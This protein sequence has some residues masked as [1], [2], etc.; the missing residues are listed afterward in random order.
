MHLLTQSALLKA[1]GWSLF[2]SC[3][4]M[5]LLWLLYR[6]LLAIFHKASAHA[7]HGLACLVLG[8]GLVWAALSG[9]SPWPDGIFWTGEHTGASF[10]Q[11]AREL[12]QEAIPYCSF[13]YLLV[14]AFLFTRYSSQVLQS[15][16]LK[17]A[18][19]SKIQ[20]GLR[21]FVAKTSRLMGIR[22]E[23]QVWLSSRI[24]VPVTLGFLKPVIL[25]PLA[26]ANNLSL[27]QVEAVLLHELAH[28]KRNDYLLH[29]GVTVLEVLFFFNPFSRLLI[30][31]IKR[32]REHRCDDMVMQF[33]YDP[34][35]YASAL[36][37]LAKTAANG[38]DRRQLALAATGSSDQLL[39]QRV[40]R[41]L[42][43]GETRDRPG[44][45][46]LV[47]LL[48]ILAGTFMLLSRTIYPGSRGLSENILETTHKS[49]HLSESGPKTASSPSGSS[50]STKS[51]GSTE[52]SGS[53]GPAPVVPAEKS[54]GTKTIKK[55]PPVLAPA[56]DPEGDPAPGKEIVSAE[57]E[58]T[59]REEAPRNEAFAMV[60]ES[61]DREYSMNPA[62]GVHKAAQS[63]KILPPGQPFVPH[64][65]FSFQ[66]VEDTAKLKE[67]YAYLQSLA[68]HEVEEA[69]KKMQKELQVQL[70][71]L[72]TTQ[73]KEL[74]TALKAQRQ[75]L[76]EQLKLQELFLHKQQEL[77]R[78]FERAGKVR[79]IVVI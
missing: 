35:T 12:I 25:I 30:R 10:W 20:P 57:D 17:R 49:G 14:L 47:I 16:Q 1:L 62:I 51:F 19:L 52:S 41:I 76:E 2:N 61:D 8:A 77:E 68:S 65:S 79:R 64:S 15:R 5:A 60:I 73:S 75:I 6:I 70:R 9:S 32:E 34:H 31:D 66:R 4:Q 43:L 55:S 48:L 78:K 53:S 39:L 33:R 74:K 63:L 50:E 46:T 56:A 59:D 21:V 42:Q 13:L 37:S 36:L 40:R 72:Q 38:Q 11:A 28:I 67:Q 23:V 27:E 7:R 71:V 54:P 44:A 26:T 29:L 58:D 24:A 18:G 45:R 3:W 22:Q 69:V